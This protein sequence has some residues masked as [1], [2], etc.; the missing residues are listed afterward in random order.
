MP[1]VDELSVKT[2]VTA[3]IAEYVREGGRYL[4]LCAGAYFAAKDLR[5][6]AGGK[7]EV[8]GKRDLVS[9]ACRGGLTLGLLPRHRRRPNIQPL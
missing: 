2:K 9:T 4:G 5:F 6:D 3:R 7:Q 8:I 1:Y